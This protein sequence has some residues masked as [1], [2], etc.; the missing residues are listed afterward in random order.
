MDAEALQET[1]RK[2]AESLPAA[3]LE[4]PFGPDYD[5]FK[6]RG[7]MFLM[8]TDVPQNS[9]G[10]GVDESSRGQPVVVVKA[11]PG[12]AEALREG[13]AD[14][15]PGYHL[16]KRHWITVAAGNSI[17]KNLIEELVTESYRL[18]IDTLP[19]SRHPIDP[20]TYET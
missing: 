4:Q 1:A 13:H 10:H 9:V 12:E 20:E 5:V 3:Q 7:K 11:D 17:D 6:V 8:L 19:K 16:D 2:H 14:I 18:A 15:S